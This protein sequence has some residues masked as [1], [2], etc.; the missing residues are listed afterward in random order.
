MAIQKVTLEIDIPEGYVAT[1]EYRWP[2]EGDCF[3]ALDRGKDKPYVL[4]FGNGASA[5]RIILRRV[6]PDAVKL[7]RFVSTKRSIEWFCPG[8]ALQWAE[9]ILEA[10]ERDGVVK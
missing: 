4:G 10:Y 7:A 5:P 3:V 1:G 6:E 2:N 9:S 8:E